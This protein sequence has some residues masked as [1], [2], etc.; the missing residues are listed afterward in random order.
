MHGEPAVGEA[1]KYRANHLV[2]DQPGDKQVQSLKGVKPDLLILAEPFGRQDD[3]G[4]D[5]PD[6]GD[7][8]EDRRCA[9]RDTRQRVGDRL[10]FYRLPRATAGAIEIARRDLESALAAVRHVLTLRIR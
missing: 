10:G 3:N 7:I 9:G 2:D 8:T 5:P 1:V 6:H 4:G